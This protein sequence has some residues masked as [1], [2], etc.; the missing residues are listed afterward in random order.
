MSLL[1]KAKKPDT[2]APMITIVG[3]PGTGKT[4]LGAM[5]P[6]ALILPT[7][8]GTAVFEN[9]D[10]RAAGRAATL[11]K[12]SKGWRWQHCTQPACNAQ[13]HHG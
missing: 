11:T 2:K 9:W 10:R 4:T 12:S 13:L 6:G 1:A 3:S 8:D 7:E 5:F